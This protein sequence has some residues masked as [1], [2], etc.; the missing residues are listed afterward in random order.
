MRP[1]F[2]I[3][4]LS[5]DR[6]EHTRMGLQA[7]LEKLLR[8]FED[9]GF[10]PRVEIVPADPKLRPILIANRWR[11]TQP[12][13]E[14]EK[15]ELWKY[16]ARKIAEPGGFVVFHYDGD[17]PWSE[18]AESPARAQFDREIRRRVEQALVASP[19]VPREAVAG[20]LGRIIECVPFYSVEA[21]TYQATARATAL[22]GEK[23]RGV[24]AQKFEAW[25]RDRTLLDD[26]PKPKKQSCLEDAHNADLGKHVPVWDVVQAGCSMTW[27]VW[28]LHGHG[29]LEDALASPP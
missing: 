15:R 20:Y 1:R 3:A 29:G 9:D 24:D 6:S 23:Y 26:L 14:A 22:C 2:S 27:F 28:C 11:S 8:R 10:T 18:R 7:I 25:G 4:L 17:T 5:E 19:R 21:W 13:D 12:R 16:L